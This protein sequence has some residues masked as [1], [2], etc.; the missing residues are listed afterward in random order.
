MVWFCFGKKEL[1]VQQNSGIRT[2][3][4][5]RKA[6]QYLGLLY[7]WFA[8]QKHAQWIST[9]VVSFSLFHFGL[10]LFWKFKIL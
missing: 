10:F 4:Y 2:F 7:D 8:I 9:Y 1:I 5:E 3:E 6:N